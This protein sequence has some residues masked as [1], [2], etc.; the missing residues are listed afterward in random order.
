MYIYL[1]KT[2]LD[3]VDVYDIFENLD[4]QNLRQL[5]VFAETGHILCRDMMKRLFHIRKF[6]FSTIYSNKMSIRAKSGKNFETI[7]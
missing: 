3:V 6:L 7:G 2:E 5:M 4:K 1:K